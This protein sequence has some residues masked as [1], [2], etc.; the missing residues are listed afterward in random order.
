MEVALWCSKQN[1]QRAV[2]T[3]TRD[4]VVGP[5][6]S[7]ENTDSSCPV[8]VG[9]GEGSCRL[10]VWLWH[11]VGPTFLHLPLF[12]SLLSAKKFGEPPVGGQGQGSGLNSEPSACGPESLL[13]LPCLPPRRILGFGACS[14]LLLSVCGALFNVSE[15]EFLFWGMMMIT[16]SLGI[17]GEM[18]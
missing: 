9:G 14:P 4:K 17:L 8:A 16:C 11:W 1:K 10:V 5:D 15:C 2:S 3:T 7:T 18:L 12:W 6:F 13:T